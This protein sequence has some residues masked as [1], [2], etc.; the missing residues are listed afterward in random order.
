MAPRYQPPTRVQT[1][2]MP[3]LALVNQSDPDFQRAKFWEPEYLLGNRYSFAN[4]YQRGAY[5]RQTNTYPVGQ[6]YGG[7]DPLITA[8]LA[9][10]A[11]NSS[12]G[13]YSGVATG[14]WA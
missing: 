6:Q 3:Y 13:L 8:A 11:G 14:G 12:P 7:L 10:T 2:Q 9:T 4:R 5:N 1:V